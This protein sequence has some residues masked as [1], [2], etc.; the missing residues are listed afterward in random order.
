MTRKLHNELCD[1]SKNDHVTL[2]RETTG[3]WTPECLARVDL[4][5]WDP[6]GIPRRSMKNV[7]WYSSSQVSTA[8]MCLTHSWPQQEAYAYCQS[9]VFLWLASGAYV[10]SLSGMRLILMNFNEFQ[11]RWA[12][13]LRTSQLSW[14]ECHP[15][16]PKSKPT[17][18]WNKLS[19]PSYNHNW[20]DLHYAASQGNLNKIKDIFLKSGMAKLPID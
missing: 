20:T 2:W 19:P 5:G 12:M 1:W 6:K 4:I 18:C 13:G 17:S 9:G 10:N 11:M 7:K 8:N 16:S 15:S 14:F 3:T